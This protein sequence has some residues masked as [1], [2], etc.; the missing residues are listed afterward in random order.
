MTRNSRPPPLQALGLQIS[1][2]LK[3]GEEDGF[4]SSSLTLDSDTILSGSESNGQEFYS[5][6][7]KPS[8]LSSRSVLHEYSPTIVG[9]ND[10]TF[11]PIV[12]QKSTKFFNWDNIISR[13]FMQ[14]PFSVTHQFFEEFQYSIITSHFLNDMNHYR[15]SLHLNQS[16][17]N[18]HK[19]SALLKKVPPKS[20]PFMA[21]KYGKLAVV[22]NKKLY[23]KQN[24]NYL[25]MIIISYRVLRLLK[26]YCTKK[27]SPSL[28]RVVGSILVAVYLSIQQEYFRRHLVCYKTL[29]KIRKVLES[30]QQV[31]VMIHKY[32]L[33]FKEI[34]NQ[35]FISR[36]SLISNADEHSSVI[37]EL[38]I[39][40]SDAL[41]YKL[42]TVIPDIVIFSDTSELSKYCELYG[43]DVSILYYNSTATVKDLDGKIYRLKLLKKFMLCC[44]LSLNMTGKANFSNSSMQ[45]ALN[46]IFPDYTVKVQLKKT[47]NPIGTFQNIVSLLRELHSLLSVVL[48]S[49]NDHKQ[50]LYAFPE[51]ALTTIGNEGINV[52]SFSKS[53]EL[54]Q[55][56][57]Y[58]KA[59]ENNLL[60][61]DVRNGITE[62]D[63]NII[64]DKLEELT[65]FWK[66]SKACN[67]IAK[68]KKVP[69]TNTINRGFH[70]DILKGRKSPCSSPVK[71]LS[72]ERKVDFI[73]VDES[74]N[75]SLENHTE[76][77]DCEDYDGQEEYASGM[78]E[79]HRVG[80]NGSNNFERPDFKQLSDNELR[81]KLD[82]RILKLA[83]ENREGRE[84]LRTAK[85]FE[86]LRRTQAPIPVQFGFQKPLKGYAFP[87]SR[88]LSKC[89]VSSEET[90]PI[91]YELEGLLGNDS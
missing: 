85:S 39:F 38:L 64:E 59:I 18:F 5:T 87:E 68:I 81:R 91:M 47:Y 20:L 62:N 14:Q 25:S 79:N 26:K 1:S 72:L 24:F 9:S 10:G 76:L 35:R 86:L 42:K 77:E 31:D 63:R 41:F 43:I 15:L 58:L 36:V 66:T 71:G 54:F 67:N 84:R 29:L 55:A 17:M 12:V 88:P 48:V 28:K 75:E 19:S 16:I 33:R 90:I 21:T 60:S 40:S 51:E 78:H 70:L 11:S 44:L 23:L 49:L 74:E 56:L 4:M 80:F 73:D 7:R 69:T 2:K 37:E 46:K 89:K 3:S 32:H 34:K 61:I 50:I 57:N 8:Q 52:C 22:E 6:W 45:N 82:E 27:N 83:Q 30:L 53:D 65:T 13:I